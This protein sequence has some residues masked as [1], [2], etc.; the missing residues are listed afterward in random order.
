MFDFWDQETAANFGTKMQT[1]VSEKEHCSATKQ[2]KV[3]KQAL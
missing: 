2:E 1:F 3:N